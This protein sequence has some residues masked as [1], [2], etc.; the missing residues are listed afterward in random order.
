MPGW[1]DS[2]ATLLFLW[3]CHKQRPRLQ[4]CPWVPPTP[5]RHPRGWGMW[6]RSVP[7]HSQPAAPPRDLWPCSGGAWAQ[8]AK[9]PRRWGP[10]TT[11]ALLLS[12]RG[13][14]G[15]FT[16]TLAGAIPVQERR[17]RQIPLLAPLFR[18]SVGQGRREPG[19][20]QVS[21]WK[22]CDRSR[23]VKCSCASEG[24]RPPSS[25]NTDCRASAT[26]A[27]ISLAFL[28]QR[29]GHNGG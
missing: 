5:H 12:G 17:Q 24:D 10:P 8:G 15:K 19:H 18:Q 6:G 23:A 11:L 13:W 25:C 14:L 2:H 1:R 22:R 26:A 7:R 28:G 29:A 3:P 16:P 9:P 27:G 4:Q 21:D 20:D